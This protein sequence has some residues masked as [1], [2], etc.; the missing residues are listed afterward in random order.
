M[1]RLVPLCEEAGDGCAFPGAGIDLDR[2]FMFKGHDVLA[3]ALCFDSDPDFG[4]AEAK[5]RIIEDMRVCNVQRNPKLG[6]EIFGSIQLGEPV[7]EADALQVLEA[8][9]TARHA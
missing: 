1:V 5:R 6:P 7:L 2:H 8:I 9:I 3:L 4:V